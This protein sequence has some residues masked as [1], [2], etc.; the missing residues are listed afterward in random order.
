M[1]APPSGAAS[2]F[3]PRLWRD[4]PLGAAGGVVLLLFLVVRR[5]RAAGSRPTT[6][7]RSRRLDRMQ[8]PGAAH[9]FGTDNLGRDVLSRCIYG[10]Q[11]SVIIGCSAAR[12]PR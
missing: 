3:W 1:P 4:K 9:W 10:A 8:A 7:T 5:L 2:S 12:W 6:S 11:L